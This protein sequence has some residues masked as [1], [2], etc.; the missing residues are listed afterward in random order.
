MISYWRMSQV[1]SFQKPASSLPNLIVL[2]TSQDDPTIRIPGKV[3]E[4]T[5]PSL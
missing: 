3:I 1:I 5:I 2:I 4:L